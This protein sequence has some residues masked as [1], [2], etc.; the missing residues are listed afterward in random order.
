[1]GEGSLDRR[2]RILPSDQADRMLSLWN[3]A[4]LGGGHASESAPTQRKIEFQTIA[5]YDDGAK[6]TGQ[7]GELDHGVNNLFPV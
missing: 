1:M 2:Q 4:R 7:A 5:A 3:S 6:L